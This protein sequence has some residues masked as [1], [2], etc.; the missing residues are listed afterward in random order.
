MK[1]LLMGNPNVGKSV[2]F[3]NLTGTRV[4]ASNYPGTTVEFTRGL[5]KLNKKIVEV[6]DVPGTYSLDPTCKAEEVAVKMLP[7]GD[8]IINV[9]DSTNLERNLYLTL[10]LLEK[11]IPMVV[12]LNIW[13]E[14]EHKGIHID[15]DKLQELLGVPVVTTTAVS[16]QG[17]KELVCSL[18]QAAVSEQKKRT[19]NERWTE[20]GKIINRV[21]K[22]SHRHH[23][24]LEILQDASVKPLTGFPIAA[25]FLYLA[26]KLII[27]T[28][29]GIIEYVMEP[30]FEK[31]YLP[32]LE[33]LSLLT[34][35]EGII[36]DILIGRLIE[37][38]ICFEE[39][40]GLLST[41]LF[42]PLAVVLPYLLAF[43]LALSLMEDFG[44]LPRLAIM[45]DRFMHR[46]GLHGYAIIPMFLGLGCNVPAALSIRNLESR[47]ER[48]IASTLMAITI[49]CIAQLALIFAL[50]SRYGGSYLGVV[51]ASLFMIAAALGLII[52]RTV[53]G[54]T[55]SMLI[56]IPPYRL[57]GVQAIVKKLW[58]RLL[59]FFKEGI[60]FVMLGIVFINI[61]YALGIIKFLAM[62]TAPLVTWLWGL[63]G[64]AVSV[65]LIGFL[66]KDVAVVMLEPLGLTAKQL[67]IGATILVVYFP[68]AA[69]F[70]V[71]VKE[72]GI[73]DMAKAAFIM[74]TTAMAIG[75]ILN[76][77][78]DT[79]LSALALS[80]VFIA[81]SLTAA[82]FI[83]EKAEEGE[84]ED[85]TASAT[86]LNRRL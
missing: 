79:Y 60:P 11:N 76:L 8:I 53:K 2:I 68:C 1:I 6:I 31:Y 44:Y 22:V 24:W 69:T 75:G 35:T 7:Q 61:L 19:Q 34:G 55:P 33:R 20:V 40:M 41:G 49:P 64:D 29:E 50:L 65:L 47:R 67:V 4:I 21:Q 17:I 43:Y 63:P 10:H 27:F 86:T 71:L 45:M 74:I 83:K 85:L 51:F 77:L 32:V 26:F 57:P 72:L 37:G 70:S 28:G 80:I 36:H 84:E 13:D 39:S 58:I 38:E 54:F 46:L 73:R 62:L 56:E 25:L 18:S 81:V 48:F 42:V 5:M 82:V 78:L 52:D 14:A 59:H 9:V 23:T 12:A 3:S 15:A 16:G 30:V 66:R